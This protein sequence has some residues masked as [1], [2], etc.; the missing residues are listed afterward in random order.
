MTRAC[1]LCLKWQGQQKYYFLFVYDKGVI[2]A[3]WLTTSIY[4][5]STDMLYTDQANVLY[6]NC[7][8]GL[9]ADDS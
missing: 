4:P 2:S 3:K 9:L 1:Q 5:Q 6:Q 8:Q 7:L